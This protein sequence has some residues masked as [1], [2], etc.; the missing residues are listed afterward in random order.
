VE[1]RDISSMYWHY[2]QRGTPAVKAYQ[3]WVVR[4][5]MIAD[6][7]SGVDSPAAAAWARAVVSIVVAIVAMGVVDNLMA[8]HGASLWIVSSSRKTL[9][10]LPALM[11]IR[12]VRKREGKGWRFAHTE[13]RTDLY[14]GAER[15]TLRGE[16]P[17]DIAEPVQKAPEKVATGRSPLPTALLL[18]TF[19]LAAVVLG[20]CLCMFIRP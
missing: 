2:R 20:F 4:P 15:R 1:K 18:V 6:S 9:V 19:L 16:W 7:L 10:R 13:P 11:A 8:P 5:R 12:V 3:E 14:P 17:T